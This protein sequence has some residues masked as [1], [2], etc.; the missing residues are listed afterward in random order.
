[1]IR[2][3]CL[4]FLVAAAPAG[5][6]PVTDPVAAEFFEKEVRPLLVERCFSCHGQDKDKDIDAIPGSPPDMRRL[7]QGCSF[8]PRCARRSAACGTTIPEPH[9][10][11]PGRMAACLNL[12]AAAE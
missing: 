8:A 11:T 2:W 3:T 6:A 5:A 9:F 1:M 7:S 10:P 12:Q 4:L